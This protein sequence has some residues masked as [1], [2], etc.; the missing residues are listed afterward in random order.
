M[1]AVIAQK[2]REYVPVRLLRAVPK[3]LCPSENYNK[4]DPLR[5]KR[6]NSPELEYQK[7]TPNKTAISREI[8][9]LI[10]CPN[11]RYPNQSNA[12]AIAPS[13]IPYHS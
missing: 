6:S 7:R 5:G 4:D 8:S 9:L 11:L 10:L 3:L 1:S 2:T 13:R 12:H